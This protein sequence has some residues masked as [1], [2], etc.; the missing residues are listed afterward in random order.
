MLM[1]M[2]V[3]V[4]TVAAA[5]IA[6]A[7]DEQV[8]VNVPFSFIVGTAL[9]PEGT[10]TVKEVSTDLNV[11]SIQSNDGRHSAL[12]WTIPVA[13]DGTATQ[14]E[15]VFE[16]FGSRYFLAWRGQSLCCDRSFAGM[17]AAVSAVSRNHEWPPRI[18]DCLISSKLAT[19]VGRCD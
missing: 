9:L 14:P 5:S 7:A 12:A 10:Y 13:A 16:K 2:M 19:C 3:T 4:M 15:V 1:L 18:T 6:R 17:L 11:V 8:V